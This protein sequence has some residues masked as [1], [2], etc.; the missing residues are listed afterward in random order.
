[1]ELGDHLLLDGTRPKLSMTPKSDIQTYILCKVTIC[2]K[3]DILGTLYIYIFI[4]RKVVV[5]CGILSALRF[6][7][8]TFM[9]VL[10]LALYL[11]DGWGFPPMPAQ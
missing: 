9:R 6:I 5:S 8:G 3:L 10:V 4:Y 11:V 7:Y 2:K 1:M